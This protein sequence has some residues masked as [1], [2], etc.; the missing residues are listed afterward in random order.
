MA[1]KFVKKERRSGR[2]RW[3]NGHLRGSC[4]SGSLCIQG[5]YNDERMDAS[6][7]SGEYGGT[8][9]ADFSVSTEERSSRLLSAWF[10]HSAAWQY[11]CGRVLS[12]LSKERRHRMY[13]SSKSITALAVGLL[14]DEGKIHL[15]DSICEYFRDHQP[16]KIHPWIQETT[17]RDMLR[18]ATPVCH[19]PL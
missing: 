4:H 9:P 1:T 6:K 19:I 10:L 14:A 15:E 8:L 13:S 12:A 7:E 18:M 3:S 5:D 2:K 16:S 11:H 17:I